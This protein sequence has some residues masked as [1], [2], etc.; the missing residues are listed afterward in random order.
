ML[1][2]ASAIPLKNLM[3]ANMIYDVENELKTAATND[4]T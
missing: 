3:M 1:I 2:P 4:D